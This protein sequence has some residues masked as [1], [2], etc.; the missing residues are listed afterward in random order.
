[1]GGQLSVPQVMLF[2]AR[3]GSNGAGNIAKRKMDATGILKKNKRRK[4]AK[5]RIKS[6]VSGLN[7]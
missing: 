1:M 5:K 7:D 4:K 2:R 6:T 3:T